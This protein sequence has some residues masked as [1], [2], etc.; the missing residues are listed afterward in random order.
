MSTEEK[1]LKTCH[2]IAVVGLSDNP[3]RP[4]YN[5]ARYMLDSGYTI[6]PVNPMCKEVFGLVS[7][8]KLTDIP[9]PVD[10]VD[11]FRRSEEVPAIVDD[12][13]KIEAKAVWLQEG[14]VH[15]KAGKKAKEAG[16]LFVE[17][18]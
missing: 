14:I 16:L 9:C 7:Y 17:D 2:T 18:K 15:E 4:S 13:I 1:I 10:A 11:V 5:V 8:P 6:I 12:A 3:S